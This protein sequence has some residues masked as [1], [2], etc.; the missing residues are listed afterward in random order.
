MQD[1]L[2]EEETVCKLKNIFEKL[3]NIKIKNLDEL[4]FGET[5]N[6]DSLKHLQLVINIETIF[7]IKIKTSDVT[8]LNTFN[9]IKKYILSY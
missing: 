6:W 1:I 5:K 8:K 7:S 4:V 2:K 9:K 3:L